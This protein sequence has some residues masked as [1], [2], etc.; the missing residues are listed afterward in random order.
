MDLGT[1]TDEELAKRESQL[2]QE[3]QEIAAEQ[4][5]RD[6]LWV[7]VDRIAE[8]AAGQSGYTGEAVTRAFNVLIR[9][10]RSPAHRFF[11][12]SW[13][14]Q[15]GAIRIDGAIRLKSI[16][17]IAGNPQFEQ[18]FLSGR[19]RGAGPA[20]FKVILAVAPNLRQWLTEAAPSS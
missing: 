3:L 14:E 5:R 1:L 16:E 20:R 13:R 7:R 18:D 15:T 11:H 4:N 12:E 8:V 10:M 6:G 17:I 2:R 9:A 19:V